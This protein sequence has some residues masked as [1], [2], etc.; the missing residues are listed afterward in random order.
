MS[1]IVHPS[2][3]E[4]ADPTF[5]LAMEALRP[6]LREEEERR[7]LKVALKRGS[8]SPRERTSTPGSRRRW[9]LEP[10]FR[11]P[12]PLVDR[13]ALPDGSV[14]FHFDYKTISKSVPLTYGGQLIHSSFE[15]PASPA[16]EHAGYIERD[17][18]VELGRRTSASEL[19]EKD[20]GVE[21][22]TDREGDVWVRSVFSNI[23]DE[24]WERIHYWRLIEALEQPPTL[25]NIYFNPDCSPGWWAALERRID[26]EPAVF[27]EHALKELAAY[28]DHASLQPVSEKYRSTPLQLT[29]AEDDGSNTT[30]RRLAADKPSV[31][32]ALWSAV[33][34]L[35]DYEDDNPPIR[36]EADRAGRIQI[37]IIGELPHELSAED[38]AEVV[39]RFGLHVGSLETRTLKTG[40]T[41]K[42]GLMFTTAIHAP[43]AHN[44]PRNYHFHMVAHDRP[45]RQDEC[46]DWD[47]AE[48]E[49]K[50]D[51]FGRASTTYPKREKKIACVSQGRKVSGVADAGNEFIK[52]LRRTFAEI[53]ND[54]LKKRGKLKRYDPR[55]YDEMDINRQVTE[56][57]G[58]AAASLA[59]VGVRTDV[60]DRNAAI[61]WDDDRRRIERE[62]EERRRGL[63]EWTFISASIWAKDFPPDHEHVEQMTRWRTERSGLVEGYAT[64]LL[65]LDLLGLWE[66]KARS[67]AS[68]VKRT[69]DRYLDAFREGK[70]DRQ[71]TR[72]V[73]RVRQRKEQAEAHLQA[74]A[75]ALAPYRAALARLKASL[76]VW[77]VRIREIDRE[78]MKLE[79]LMREEWE[80]LKNL[81]QRSSSKA[82]APPESG[83]SRAGDSGEPLAQRIQ[84][85]STGIAPSPETVAPSAAGA[86]DRLNSPAP[87][88]RIEPDPSGP[89][90]DEHQAPGPTLRDE[91]AVDLR[92]ELEPHKKKQA[93]APLQGSPISPAVRAEAP[94]PAAPLTPLAPQLQPHESLKPVE[95]AQ[96]PAPSPPSAPVAPIRPKEQNLE[97]TLGATEQAAAP[98]AAP[99][100]KLSIAEPISLSG[101]AP[102][103]EEKSPGEGL[104]ALA[105]TAEHLKP[106]ADASA[107]E[108]KPTS[109]TPRVSDEGKVRK[110]AVA[111][112]EPSEVSASEAMPKVVET[113]SPNERWAHLLRQIKERKIR[114]LR[115]RRTDG[116]ESFDA[117]S[118]SDADRKF[119]ASLPL[120]KVVPVL[121]PLRQEQQLEI[122]KAVLWVERLGVAC[123]RLVFDDGRT[124]AHIGKDGIRRAFNAWKN[125]PE[126][127]KAL[128]AERARRAAIDAEFAAAEGRPG[129]APSKSLAERQHEMNDLL[130]GSLQLS[131][132][133]VTD[134]V[135]LLRFGAL[136]DEL[137]KAAEKVDD[138]PLARAEVLASTPALRQLFTQ[139]EP[140]PSPAVL[141]AA[142]GLSRDR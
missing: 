124:I 43:D 80:R 93:Q 6:F 9:E 12:S 39:E 4:A 130:P 52:S 105:I 77:I 10:D 54:V 68:R 64:N 33:N 1:H 19:A 133:E 25:Y 27:R 65:A 78:W 18:A 60:A 121:D 118:L 101:A 112:P 97:A 3:F 67:T 83:E 115:V 85:A 20:C 2:Q 79:P 132:P 71:I 48:A 42:V 34:R 142:R 51:R 41:A 37:R 110:A 106:E 26:F 32:A 141:A 82:K 13:P 137:E 16:V 74:I 75:A 73:D 29:R 138:N 111:A 131:H 107:S 94:L 122:Y 104:A 125:E 21:S 17:G 76:N 62:D 53:T 114:L 46:G 45:A 136:R 91:A 72:N 59:A 123:G 120:Q 57:L 134:F 139:Y 70:A 28:R 47:F 96:Q 38:R 55:R 99:P 100:S 31:Q 58:N 108:Q 56:H 5:L 127:V 44:D 126:I 30:K 92:C 23:S 11:Y 61:L 95:T 7:C 15:A 66:K 69:C 22:R 117:P 88:I 35:P 109:I 128:A 8:A 129:L 119:L 103:Q 24:P 98:T 89:I 86:L 14:T 63:S 113:L 140:G 102:V 84:S 135:R 81:G 90:A 36:V 50:I 49:H 40:E 116:S 87:S